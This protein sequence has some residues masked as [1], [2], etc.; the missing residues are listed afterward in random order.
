M[1]QLHAAWQEYHSHACRE[2]LKGSVARSCLQRGVLLPLLWSLVVDKLT[3]GLNVNGCYT[4]VYA[5]DIA[6][7]IRGK[8][9][10][11]ISELQQEALSVVQQ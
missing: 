6:I 11:T 4:L 2:N 7:H 3:G 10:N 9:P 5:D 1:D 8:F